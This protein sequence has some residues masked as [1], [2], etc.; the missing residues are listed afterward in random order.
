MKVVECL[1]CDNRYIENDTFILTCPS[2]N[3][4]D[5]N[6]TIYLEEEGSVYKTFMQKVTS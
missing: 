5:T 1:K 2:C 4:A 3:N 6:Q